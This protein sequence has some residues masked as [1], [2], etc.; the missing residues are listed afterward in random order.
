MS[1]GGLGRVTVN[2]GRSR[3]LGAEVALRAYLTDQLSADLAYGF[4]HARFRNE[5]STFVPFVPRNTFSVG[6]TQRW[7]MPAGCWLD[8][9]SLHADYSGAGRIYWN[10]QNTAWQDFNGQ[11]RKSTR[12]NSSH[13]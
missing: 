1:T 10:E 12:L 13:L 7:P 9:L 4:T 6:A 8:A 2:S 5:A 3:S 11:D